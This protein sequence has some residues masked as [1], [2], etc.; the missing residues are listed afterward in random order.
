MSEIHSP[1]GKTFTSTQGQKTF[2]VEDESE[3][4]NFGRNPYVE[5]I[6]EEQFTAARVEKRHGGPRISAGAKTRIELLTGIG[7]LTKEVTVAN[8]VFSIRTL[9]HGELRDALISAAGTNGVG[10]AF[11]ARKQQLARS[12]FLIDG[13]DMRQVLGTDDMETRLSM[14]EE[15]DET[16]VT[17]LFKAYADLAQEASDKFTIKTPEQA[18]ELADDLKK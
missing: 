15:L 18:K 5:P 16:L 17:V 1:I 8:T 10:V 7:R 6:S 4:Q 9:K 12:I 11:E 3:N 13:Y 2:V 14:I